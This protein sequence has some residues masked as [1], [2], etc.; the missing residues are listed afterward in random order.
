MDDYLSVL[1]EELRDAKRRY[2]NDTGI[3]EIGRPEVA[4]QIRQIKRDIRR[5]SMSERD[6]VASKHSENS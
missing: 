6:C 5:I 4:H 2:R 3:N 1:R